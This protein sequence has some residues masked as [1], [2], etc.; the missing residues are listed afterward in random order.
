MIIEG[1][2]MYAP[3]KLNIMEL[4]FCVRRGRIHKREFHKGTE[5]YLATNC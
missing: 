4:E 5:R 1:L 2:A 3:S